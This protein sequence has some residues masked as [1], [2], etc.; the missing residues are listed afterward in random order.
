M[1][2]YRLSTYTAVPADLQSINSPALIAG[3]DFHQMLQISLA[4]GDV[5]TAEPG[6]MVMMSGGLR[7]T[8]DTGGCGQGCTR[9]CCAGEN[10]FRLVFENTTQQSQFLAIAAQGPGKVIPLPLSEWSGITLSSGVFLAAYGKDWKYELTTVGSCLTACCG[11]QGIFLP[12]LHGS[13]LAFISASGAVEVVDLSEGE[14]IIVDQANLVAF[15]KGVSFEV[16][17]VGGCLVCCC[18]GMGLFNVV[19]KGPGKVIVESLPMQKLARALVSAA[20]KG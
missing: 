16:R 5:L 6:T 13:G 19:L 10:L 7:P 4:P 15:Q 17:S 8:V 2:V 11:G 14:E 18:A 3:T 20:Q 9:C 1:V 12:R